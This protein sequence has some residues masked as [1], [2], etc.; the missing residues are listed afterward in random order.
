MR[1]IRVFISSSLKHQQARE[2]IRD[3]F[4]APDTEE[5]NESVASFDAYVHESEKRGGEYGIIERVSSQSRIDAEADEHSVFLLYAGDCVGEMTIREFLRARSDANWNVKFIY[6]LHNSKDKVARDPDIEYIEWADF[7]KK[8][9]QADNGSIYYEL[10]TDFDKLKNHIL[11]IRRRLAHMTLVPL[12]PSDMRY[13][14]ITYQEEYRRFMEYVPRPDTDDEL[15]RLLSF[16]DGKARTPLSVVTGMSLAGKT[17]SVTEAIRKL[18]P[19]K[20]KIHFIQGHA[21]LSNSIFADLNFEKQFHEGWHHV[22]FIDEFSRLLFNI[23]NHGTASLRDDLKNKFCQLCRFA[24]DKPGRLTIIGTTADDFGIVK[25]TIVQNFANEPWLDSIVNVDVPTMPVEEMWT[26]YRTLRAQNKVETGAA[27]KIKQGMPIGA[28]FVDLVS[29]RNKYKIAV[30]AGKT[31][32]NIDEAALE[33]RYIFDAIKSLWLWKFHSRAD[34]ELLLDYYRYAYPDEAPDYT[35]E[36][37]RERL[38]DLQA[39]ITLRRMGRGGRYQYFTEQVLVDDVFRFLEGDDPT[40]AVNRLVNYIFNHCSDNKYEELQKLSTRLLGKGMEKEMQRVL[41]MAVQKIGIDN[42]FADHEISTTYS[43]DTHDWTTTFVGNL[44]ENTARSKGFD[45]AYRLYLR[46]PAHTTLAALMDHAHTEADKTQ[47]NSLIFADGKPINGLLP[48]IAA[49]VN[50]K[51]IMKLAAWMELSEVLS[52][53]SSLDLDDRARRSEVEDERKSFDQRVRNHARKLMEIMLAK[54]ETAP[55]IKTVFRYF[56]IK[57]ATR[58]EAGHEPWFSSETELFFSFV[59]R[60]SWQEVGNNVVPQEL[61]EVFRYINSLKVNATDAYNSDKSYALNPL[62]KNMP[63]IDA[64]QAWRSMG[65]CRDSFTLVIMLKKTDDFAT[66]RSIVEEFLSLDFGK[67]TK[68]DAMIANGLLKNAKTREDIVECVDVYRQLGLLKTAKSNI[69]NKVEDLFEIADEYTQGTIIDKGCVALGEKKKLLRMHLDP[70]KVRSNSSIGAI[71][72]SH[73]SF[74]DAYDMLFG[75]TP[76]YITPQEQRMLATSPITIGALIRKATAA[77]K[78]VLDKR[79]KESL[80]IARDQ[81]YLP[82]ILDPIQA[83]I[84]NEYFSNNELGLSHAEMLDFEKRL[85]DFAGFKVSNYYTPAKIIAAFIKTDADEA[86]RNN[87]VNEVIME[88]RQAPRNRMMRMLEFRIA[89]MWN[90][91]LLSH[92]T[93]IFPFYTTSREWE[94]RRVTTLEWC[95]NLLRNRFLPEFTLSGMLQS[96]TDRLLNCQGV[97]R[98]RIEIKIRDLVEKAARYG[99][100]INQKKMIPRRRFLKKAKLNIDLRP[101][102]ENYSLINDI[103]H[104]KYIDGHKFGIADAFAMLKE[105]E[106]KYG[107]IIRTSTLYRRFIELYNEADQHFSIAQILT[108]MRENGFS[109]SLIVNNTL[110]QLL[111]MVR[112][113]AEFDMLTEAT[114]SMRHK[115]HLY[116]AVYSAAG[117]CM[118][119]GRPAEA[120]KITRRLLFDK[121]G[122]L[123][124]HPDAKKDFVARFLIHFSDL[125]IDDVVAYITQNNLPFEYK[126]ALTLWRRLAF[127]EHSDATEDIVV[128]ATYGHFDNMAKRLASISIPNY[129]MARRHIRMLIRGHRMK[130]DAGLNQSFIISALRSSDAIDFEQTVQLIEEFGIEVDSYGLS[131]LMSMSNNADELRQALAFKKHPFTASNGGALLGRINDYRNRILRT[132]MLDMVDNPDTIA[133]LAAVC[134]PGSKFR[135]YC[136]RNVDACATSRTPGKQHLVAFCQAILNSSQS[137]F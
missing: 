52:F 70:A 107:R 49:T 61:P 48:D 39:F 136:Q 122:R 104:I 76:D 37:L 44:I 101:I 42:I 63:Y 27:S 30:D 125:P 116:E 21:H 93:D 25:N 110:Y 82:D 5:D 83:N 97:D 51:L 29:L 71:V 120:R 86:T 102:T 3:A 54:V 84:L 19:A 92:D 118:E 47:I 94:L 135:E 78:D 60:F 4:E 57:N 15:F 53:F 130:P 133:E 10:E 45:A 75:P 90:V 43:D 13:S 111:H 9:M 131:H 77:D 112:S 117:D 119:C 69:D 24:V 103:L 22:L 2:L 65:E 55:Q 113:A 114:G 40:E 106:D 132:D 99:A 73:Y 14:R 11:G 6:V 56:K 123:D 108:E 23:D 80:L 17:R 127:E 7:R 79:L 33:N 137:S 16:P 124:P 100:Y 98:S 12:A 62:L 95:Q 26:L 31:L 66:A 67:N 91:D 89:E 1:H 121:N 64:L 35:P 20:V 34:M 50:S 134:T 81:G 72:K 115:T 59:K 96:L 128:N 85:E 18:D 68:F 74:A 8:Y 58:V 41:D 88:N 126:D 38:K 28:L 46:R 32:D 36:Q 105:Y 87:Y 129:A 109:D